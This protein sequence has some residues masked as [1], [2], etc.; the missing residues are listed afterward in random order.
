MSKNEEGKYRPTLLYTSFIKE[1][2]RVRMY[3]IKKYGEPGDDWK[4]T[5]AIRH[6]DAMLRHIFAFLDGEEVD[7]ESGLSHL[8]HAA[9]N[10]M[11]E[12]ERRKGKE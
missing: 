8:A 4:T 7:S 11:F 2:S 5:E 3:G 1:V 6:F 9:T 12:I 10:L